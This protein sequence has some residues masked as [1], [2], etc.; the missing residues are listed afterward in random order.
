MHNSRFDSTIDYKQRFYYLTAGYI[1]DIL[2]TCLILHILRSINLQEGIERSK[3]LVISK[4][5][6][7]QR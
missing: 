3:R 6:K 2:K 5:G 1:A 4:L 7:T